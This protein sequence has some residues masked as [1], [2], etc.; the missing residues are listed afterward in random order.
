MAYIFLI[1]SIIRCFSIFF[2]IYFM[3]ESLMACYK[4]RNKRMNY[5]KKVFM[6]NYSKNKDP[7]IRDKSPY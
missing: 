3:G 2:Y 4:C 5:I 1:L 6:S 7:I